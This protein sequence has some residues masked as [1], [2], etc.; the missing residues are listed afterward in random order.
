MFITY[1]QLQQVEAKKYTKY[2]YYFSTTNTEEE[3]K[4]K[5]RRRMS[6]TKQY[7]FQ[8]NT[9]S[10]TQCYAVFWGAFFVKHTP[11]GQECH[12]TAPTYND[13]DMQRAIIVP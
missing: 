2:E 7:N 8:C 11:C 12:N 5:K 3:K 13:D 9:C 6:I 1:M 10:I 4:K